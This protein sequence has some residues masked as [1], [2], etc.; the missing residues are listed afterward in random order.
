M[1]IGCTFLLLLSLTGA[2]DAAKPNFVLILADDL[3]YGDI[4]CYGNTV[5]RTPH[6][7]RLARE[8]MRFTDFHANG[9]NCS[10]TRAALLTGRYQQRMGIE[11]PLG[12]KAAGL[13]K[14][15]VTIA[16]RLQQAGYATALVGKWHLGYYPDNGPVRHGFDQFVGHLHGATDY[17]SHVDQYGRRDWWHNDR[18]V[19]E[20]GYNTTLITEHALRFIEAHRDG[21]FFLMVSHSAIHFPWMVPDDE[22]H[23]QP[24][25]RYD[26]VTGKLGPHAQGPV[27]PVVQRMI[28]EM[29]GSVGRIVDKLKQL[30]L[31]R[32]TLVFFASDN[33]GILQQAGV[34]ITPANRISSN[35]PLRGQKHGLYE[36]GH[37]VPAIAWWPGHIRPGV[38]SA[39]TAMTMDL[40]PTLLD[41]AGLDVPAAGEAHALDGVSLRGEL[42][43]GDALAERILFWRNGDSAAVRWR[44]WKL[45]RIHG[46]PFGLYDLQE[47][48]GERH[49][50]AQQHPE[51]VQKLTAALDAWQEPF[52]REAR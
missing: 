12:E 40:H 47:D 13:A 43:G 16:D 44:A 23:R 33:G 26:T 5:N 34:A 25:T 41:L 14:S 7:D 6:L 50:L 22:A 10:P 17:I 46:G 2:A 18:P 52:G 51:I 19:N 24:G 11:G 32:H 9:A 3:G 20:T 4:G 49:D 8:G 21:P 42:L 27:Q 28:E 37:R 35:A 48:L 1:Q 29:D 39:S 38:E 30:K 36:G 31:D 15:E 45:V